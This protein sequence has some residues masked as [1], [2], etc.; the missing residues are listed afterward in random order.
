MNKVIGILL[1]IAFGLVFGAALAKC[2]FAFV[3]FWSK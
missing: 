1:F 2:F 3:E